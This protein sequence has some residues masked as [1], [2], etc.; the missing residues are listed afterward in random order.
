MDWVSRRQVEPALVLGAGPRGMG[1]LDWA[2]QVPREVAVLDPDLQEVRLRSATDCQLAS[3]DA[4]GAKPG[5]QC[6]GWLTSFFDVPSLDRAAA[7]TAGG[8]AAA[9][10]HW[11][12][13]SGGIRACAAPRQAQRGS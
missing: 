1:Q 12:S 4:C 10:A 5:R 13:G 8:E 7:A 3:C 2:Q 11:E 9:I 6:R